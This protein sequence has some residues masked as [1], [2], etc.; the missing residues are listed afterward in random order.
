MRD[1]AQPGR[2][3]RDGKHARPGRRGDGGLGHVAHQGCRGRLCDAKA[4]RARDGRQAARAVGVGPRQD[5]AAQPLAV[6]L[7]G[8]LEEDVDGRPREVQQVVHRQSEGAP[9]LDQGVVAGRRHEDDARHDGLLVLD[10]AHRQRAARAQHFGEAAGAR[11]R[12]VNDQSQREGAVGGQRGDQDAH[13]LQGPRRAPH[14]HRFN[15]LRGHR[16][17]LW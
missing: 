7:R 16:H 15:R 17:S 6:G 14:H 1:R 5:H 13:R 12:Q 2:D 8:R 9:A 11:R 10:L 3:F 4:A